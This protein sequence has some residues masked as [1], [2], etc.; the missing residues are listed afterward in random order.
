[1]LENEQL[2]GKIT[3]KKCVENEMLILLFSLPVIVIE[4]RNIGVTIL[5]ILPALSYLI[6]I[7]KLHKGKEIAGLQYI[8]HNGIFAGCFT[9]IFALDGLEV[10]LYLFSGTERSIA[11]FIVSAG[12]VF[13]FMIWGFIVRQYRKREYNKAKKIKG[14]SFLAYLASQEYLWQEP[15]LK[16]LTI[17]QFGKSYVLVAFWFPIYH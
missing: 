13:M 11:I 10:L 2:Q 17:I 16:M 7:I 6:S 14:R 5:C 8:L 3:I 1:M 15:Y 4:R 12:Y 9:V